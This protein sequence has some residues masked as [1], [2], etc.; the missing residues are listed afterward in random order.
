MSDVQ[1]QQDVQKPKSRFERYAT[2][3]TFNTFLL[4]AILALVIV[5]VVWDSDLAEA[6]KKL[7]MKNDFNNREGMIY[8]GA[9]KNVLRTDLGWSG[10]DTLA[11][12]NVLSQN[13]EGLIEAG[14]EPN[15]FFVPIKELR[16]VAG[17]NVGEEIPVRP[18]VRPASG[19]RDRMGDRQNEEELSKY[20][21]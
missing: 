8:Q 11:E 16:P 1:Q 5:I 2:Q 3:Q 10:A 13:S 14:R 4:L 6:R 17:D 18:T 9:S 19:F 12:K 20:L 21:Q 7:S 15:M